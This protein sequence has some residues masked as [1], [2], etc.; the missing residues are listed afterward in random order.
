MEGDG[1]MEVVLIGSEGGEAREERQE[2]RSEKWKTKKVNLRLARNER[3]A[4][5]YLQWGVA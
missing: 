3:S 4:L 5:V 1:W 2:V